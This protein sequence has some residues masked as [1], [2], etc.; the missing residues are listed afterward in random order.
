MDKWAET[1]LIPEYTRGTGRKPNPARKRMANAMTAARNRGDRAAMRSLRIASRGVPTRDPDDP[2]Y[3]RLRYSRY[4]DDHLLGFTGPKAEAEQIRDKLAAFLREELKLELSAAKTLITHG[5]TQKARFPGYDLIVQ[6]SPSRPRVNG[7]IGLRVPNDVVTAKSA[8]YRR[9]GTPWHRPHLLNLDDL[10]I[11]SIYGAEYRG[12]VQY[13]LLAGNV[14]RLHR[15]R[16]AAELSMLKTLAAKHRSTVAKTARK[17]RAVIA[18]PHGPRTCFEA[19]LERPGRK[20]LAARFGG[21]PLKRQAK[22]VL[23]DRQ[24]AP[25]ARP[26]EVITRLLRGECEWCHTRT[27][28]ETHQVRKLADLASQPGREQPAWA[29]LM[30]RMRRKTLIVCTRCHQAIHH[31]KPAANCT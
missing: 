28:V 14:Y 12:I 27:Q 16:R 20:P 6:H 4:A 17:Y 15:L 13:Y 2:G 9:H 24:P 26:K 19:Q 10:Q 11:I 18:T 25:P 8:P 21:I 31:G 22:A 7:R 29:A 3:R 23:T 5:R 1:V 30:T